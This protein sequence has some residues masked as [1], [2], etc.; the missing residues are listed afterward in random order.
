MPTFG[1][2]ISGFVRADDL[3]IVR[4]ING[5]PSGQALTDAYM[6]V[7]DVGG[8]QIFQ[9]HITGTIVVGQGQITDDGSG[10]GIAAVRFEL[11]GGAS[12]DTTQLTAGTTYNYDIQV[13][14][15]ASPAKRYT[16]ETGTITTQEQY[17]VV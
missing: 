6:T 14:T 7:K 4:T 13:N 5:V 17:T 2:T 10:D 3:D 1:A 12:G 8:S 11:T 16:P 15:N 9:K